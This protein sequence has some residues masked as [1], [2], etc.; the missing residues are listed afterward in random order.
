[1]HTRTILFLLIIF[2]CNTWLCGNDLKFK[3][4]N[5]DDGISGSTVTCFY[6]SHNQLMW[7]GTDKGIDLFTG[8][9][10]IP[11]H[12][13]IVDSAHTT[14]SSIT[15]ITT[16]DNKTLWAG[17][18]GDGLFSVN[19]ETGQYKHYWAA[20]ELNNSTISD[21]YI[22]CLEVFD[23]QLWIGTN[24]CLSHTTGNGFTHYEFEEVLTKGIPDIRGII[25]RYNQLLSIFTN[26]GEIIELNSQT[27]TY[28]KVAEIAVPLSNITRVVKDKY[29]RYWIGTEYSGLILLDEN[30]QI[31]QPEAP[32]FKSLKNSHISDLKSHPE[33]G[34]FVSSD[35]GGLFLINPDN[36]KYKH[37]KHDNDKNSLASNQLE[38]LL[39]DDEG[40]LWIGYFKGGF[41]KANYEG[42]GIK[43]YYKRNILPNRNVNCF[44]EDFSGTIWI[45]TENGLSILDKSFKQ[46]NLST[47][48]KKVSKLLQNYPVT[49]LSTNH[50]KEKVYIGTYNNGLF[51]INL[52]KKSIVNLTKNNSRLQ[53]NFIR[54]V[55]EADDSTLYI[56]SVDGG[57]YKYDGNVCEKIKVYYQNNYEIQDFFHIELID[58]KSLWLSSAGKGVLRI[59]TSTGSG[60]LFDSVI[61]TI[62]YST[63]ITK[64]S[65]VYIAT[66]KGLFEYNSGNNEFNIVSDKYPN[67]EYYGISESSKEYLWIS[68]SSGLF[69]FNRT[70]NELEGINS[71]NIQ[72]IEF[73]PGSFY[74]LDNGMLLF[75]G[76]NGFNLIDTEQFTPHH[77]TPEIFISELKIYNTSIKPGQPHNNNGK[78][79]RQINYVDEISI[80]ADIDLFSLRVNSLSYR[81]FHTNKVA[82][83]IT[84]NNKES[85]FFYADG[86]I[87]FLN[88]KP[89]QYE[90]SIYPI[91]PSNNE[92]IKASAKKISIIKHSPWWRSYWVYIALLLVISLTVLILHKLR[93][94]EYRR[95]EKILQK[96][97]TE[98]TAALLSQKE[99]LQHQKN[100]LQQILVKNEKLESFKEVIISMIIHDLKNP[101][102]GIIGLSSLNE[103]EY[104]EH[105]N[106]SSRQM[107]CLVENI[108]DV[109]RYETHSLKLFYQHCDIRQLAN[110]AI[111]EVRFLLKNNQIEIINLTTP[112]QVNVDKDIMRRV[113][114]NLLTNAIKYSKINGKITLRSV[115]NNKQNEKTLLL[116]VQDEGHGI[117]DDFKESIFDLYQ[118]IELKKSGQANSNGLGL[119]FCKIAVNEHHG[120]IWVESAIGKGSTFNIEIPIQ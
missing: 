114:I 120:K 100:E 76:T 81:N 46:E 19:I 116:S 63:C 85:E 113:Y 36:L 109:R 7:L 89:G 108:L 117:A 90:L 119:S 103:V 111:D 55:K 5:L 11:L 112:M 67:I 32:F 79:E 104:L 21:N 68:S 87:I 49:S 25:P 62:C 96:K 41:S 50:N 107:L 40:L 37:F 105:I 17:T 18:W 28:K 42:D 39:I 94:R 22:N 14:Q 99:R 93:T 35:G 106:S 15:D 92:V 71:L 29:K 64:D 47:F 24:Y 54:S 110:E 43:H 9:D 115:T 2:G 75:G 69:R 59:N 27:G 80:A 20:E 61:S 56:A 53:S 118:Q 48:N 1:M 4:F 95:T 65:S 82:Y 70:N 77:D 86:E 88:M 30:Y 13:F 6:K 38:S 44:A 8:H 26:S 91:N 23:D 16:L 33:Y 101:L 12:Q 58:D 98:R 66:N 10:F 31:L 52:S 60:E 57:L 84:Q 3:S 34:V 78:L 51:I 83:K 74:Q 97:V 102:N 72:N 73:H 45:G